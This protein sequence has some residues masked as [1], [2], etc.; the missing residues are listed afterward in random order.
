MVRTMDESAAQPKLTGRS[1]RCCELLAAT[2][3]VLAR[4]KAWV[5]LILVSGAESEL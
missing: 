3:G 2:P 4:A 5:Y 1:A